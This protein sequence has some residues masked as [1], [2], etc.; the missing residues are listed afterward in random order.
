M[1]KIKKL[2]DGVCCPVGEI[3]EEPESEAKLDRLLAEKGIKV[4][5]GYVNPYE[6]PYVPSSHVQDLMARAKAKEEKKL[7]IVQKQK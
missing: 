6:I 5:R 7:K 3:C 1:E 2:G 4:D